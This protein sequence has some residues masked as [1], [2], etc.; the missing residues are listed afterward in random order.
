LLKKTS[1]ILYFFCMRIVAD[2]NIP[3]VSEAFSQFGRVTLVNGREICRET[4]ADAD[5]LL[6]RSVTKVNREL[7]DHTSVRF[8]GTAT[9]GTD[10]VDQEYLAAKTV[11]FTAAPGSNALSVAQYLTCALVC[12][13]RK[14]SMD[15]NGKILGIIGAGNV[16][17]RV[18]PLARALGMRCML[19]DPPLQRASSG[20]SFFSLEQL[21]R[22]SDALTLHVPLTTTGADATLGMA[23]DGFFKAMKPGAI[24]INTSRGPVVT[25]EALRAHRDKLAAIVL[26]VWENEPDINLETLRATDIATP[27]IAGYSFDGKVSGTKMLYEAACAFFGMQSRWSA[28]SHAI[29]HMPTLIDVRDASDPLAKA[30]SVAYPIDDDD[31]LLRE[32]PRHDQ[33]G[34]YFDF[35]RASYRTRLEFEHFRA[36]CAPGHRKEARILQQLGFDVP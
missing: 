6:V 33:R 36:V 15:L 28:V 31:A 8:V 25:E 5:I 2:R 30:L 19:C 3:L 4:V 32:I 23:H 7:I 11:G 17:F 13:S 21:L 9:I 10:H 35:L 18:A 20:S 12:I 26:D 16:G 27:H 29:A 14:L 22:E 34:A 1:G 24:F